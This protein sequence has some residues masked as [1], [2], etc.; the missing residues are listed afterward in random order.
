MLFST[1]KTT[2]KKKSY[3][4]TKKGEL[5]LHRDK[6]LLK[7]QTFQYYPFDNTRTFAFICEKI[8]DYLSII[9][10]FFYNFYY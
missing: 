7:K 1:L 2:F 5:Q 6:I 4:I 8:T 9:K 10:L 3:I